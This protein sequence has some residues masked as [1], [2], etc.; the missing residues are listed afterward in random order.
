MLN[1]KKVRDYFETDENYKNFH[2]SFM[3]DP[4]IR[5]LQTKANN[6]Q[7]AGMLIQ[8][9]R[10]RQMIDEVEIKTI[11]SLQA[12]EANKAQ[13]INLMKVGM[14]KD[15]VDKLTSLIVTAYM[16]IDMLE[17]CGID[18]E[19]ILKKQD[20]TLSYEGFDKII[21]LGKQ[22]RQQINWIG[23]N[24][25]LYDNIEWGDYCDDLFELCKNKA[26]KLIKLTDDKLAKKKKVDK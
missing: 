7:S 19:T 4:K 5:E 11:E 21:S 22:A 25:S 18:I 10:Y 6:L 2:Q 12:E 24:T 9:I 3:S 23:D 16:C 14:P 8:S 13:K 20:N 26:K 15:E 17:S 1:K